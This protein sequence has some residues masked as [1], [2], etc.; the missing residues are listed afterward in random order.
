MMYAL[1]VAGVSGKDVADPVA[2]HDVKECAQ[3]MC[4]SY[5]VAAETFMVDGCD[6]N[7]DDYILD[8]AAK[9]ESTDPTTG[10]STT[11]L[12]AISGTCGLVALI[13]GFVAGSREEQNIGYQPVP[14][15]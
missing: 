1:V 13:V 12:V 10:V 6:G 8:L 5:P 11:S 14:S 4:P 15:V 7:F 3:Y 2:R 9:S